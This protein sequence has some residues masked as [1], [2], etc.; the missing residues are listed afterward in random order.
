[1]KHA[2]CIALC[3]VL[4]IAAACSEGGEADG[5][6]E[7]VGSTAESGDA[8]AEIASGDGAVVEPDDTP[9]YE[10][11]AEP[12]S[13]RF[14]VSPD[15]RWIAVFETEPAYLA[16]LADIGPGGVGEPPASAIFGP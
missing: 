13:R 16:P 9:G 3:L 4:L 14:S 7:V 5:L 15:G 8:S 10:L 12:M 6:G 2:K 11:V 1:M